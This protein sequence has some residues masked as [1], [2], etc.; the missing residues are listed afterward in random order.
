MGRA[1]PISDDL[2][3]LVR[4]LDGSKRQVA[5]KF[6][7]GPTIPIMGLP[8][9]DNFDDWYTI[10]VHADGYQD[11]GIYPV[12]LTS[13]RL[14]DA[15][16]MLVPNDG[17]GR[18]RPIDTIQA[19]PKIYPL[20][21]NGA[22]GDVAVRYQATA[23]NQ[24]LQLGALLTIGTAI[25]DIPLDDGSSSNGLLPGGDLGSLNARSVLGMG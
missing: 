22:V 20:L 18:F 14:I 25:R 8:Y 15:Y 7:K 6:V 19:Y 16:V 21:A 9:H 13:G 10:I 2:E 11:A 1:K 24:P 23:E 5:S 17:G 12:R 4:I 3:F